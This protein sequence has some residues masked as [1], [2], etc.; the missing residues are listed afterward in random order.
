MTPGGTARN[1]PMIAQKTLTETTRGLV[2]AMNCASRVV[3]C[4]QV[5][6]VIVSVAGKRGV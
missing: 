4:C 6:E 3:V 2:S 1:M 5:M